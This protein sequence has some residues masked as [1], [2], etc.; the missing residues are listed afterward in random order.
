MYKLSIVLKGNAVFYYTVKQK[1]KIVL[2]YHRT[3]ERLKERLLIEKT[4]KRADT[5][6]TKELSSAN[7]FV[8]QFITIF[9]FQIVEKD[10]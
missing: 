3:S 8:G 4:S 1:L 10:K 6:A 5:Q 9:L 7:K 2:L